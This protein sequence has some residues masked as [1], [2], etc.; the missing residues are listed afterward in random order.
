MLRFARDLPLIS[1]T[2]GVTYSDAYTRWYPNARA[3]LRADLRRVRGG[4]R[5]PSRASAGMQLLFATLVITTMYMYFL[6]G[7]LFYAALL[8]NLL[9][10][11]IYIGMT[12]V[13]N[14]PAR[15]AAYSGMLLALTNVV[16]AVV[17]YHLE[18]ANRVG[19]LEARMLGDM[20][21]RDGLTG[22]YNRRMFDE[23]IE[24]LWNQAVR[25]RLAAC[26]AAAGHRLL[27][28]IQRLLRTPGRR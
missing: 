13:W 26:A 20:A 14:M 5:G 3:N 7:M 15:E 19:Y 4:H 11:T 10:L 27:Q 8:S 23:R 16:G 17:C 1:V 12:L 18:T 25:E 24:E 9:V 2:L 21:A 28:A 22:I 6:V